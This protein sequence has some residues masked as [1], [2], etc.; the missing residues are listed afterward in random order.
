MNWRLRPATAE[1]ASALS[2]VACA[3]FLETYAGIVSAA[4]ML[5]HC[6]TRCS[7]EH[8]GRWAADPDVA[9]TLAEHVDGAAPL[10]F[11]AL[12]PPDFPIAFG[13]GTIELRRIYVLTTAH[14]SGLGPALMDHAIEDARA[15]GKTQLA[16]GVHPGNGRARAFYERH[17][18]R[19]VGERRFQVGEALF[20][21]PVYARVI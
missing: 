5:H 18:F 8:F 20:T 2:L 3:T 13:P 16:L 6:A 12:T 19:I 4:D 10:G 9:V 11:T 7:P 14:G 21:D 17:G 1:D 15:L